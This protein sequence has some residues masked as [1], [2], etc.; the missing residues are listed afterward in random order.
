MKYRAGQVVQG[1]ITGIKPY[2]AFV[3][4]DDECDGLIHI[5][6]IS[7]NFVNN[8]SNFVRIGEKVVVKIIDIDHYNHQ[9]RLSLK[10]IHS[11]SRQRYSR[12]SSQ[13]VKPVLGFST[14]E[15]KLPQ[16]ISLEENND[17]E[18]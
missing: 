13:S 17:T 8:V 7:E 10:A 16:W 15:K 12:K 4:V 6:E 9:Y 18:N 11:S 3:R 1:V 5:S 14:L 2:G